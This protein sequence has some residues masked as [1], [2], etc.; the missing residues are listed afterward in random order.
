M[1]LAGRPVMEVPLAMEQ[2]LLSSAV[3]R[4][5]AGVAASG[6]RGNS[7]A[8]KLDELLGGE[9]DGA[10]GEF[11]SRYS[12]FTAAEQRRAMAGRVMALLG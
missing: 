4:L 12:A 3:A 2:R 7:I 8:A 9:C 1:L 6:R 11:A 10:A 5:G